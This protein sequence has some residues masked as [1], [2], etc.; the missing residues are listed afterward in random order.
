[1]PKSKTYDT[2]DEN[3]ANRRPQ[4]ANEA[5]KK[6]QQKGAKKNEKEANK[7]LVFNQK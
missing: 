5:N 2:D 6:Q 3:A 4:S 1:M 7:K